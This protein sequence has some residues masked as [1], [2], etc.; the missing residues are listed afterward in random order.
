MI[1]HILK[2]LVAQVKN[3]TVSIPLTIT[4]EKQGKKK[5]F[6]KKSLIDS[7]AGGKFINQNFPKLKASNSHC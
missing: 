5:K 2:C 6:V 3:K 1:L 4:S 7:G